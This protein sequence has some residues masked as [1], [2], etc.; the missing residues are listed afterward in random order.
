MALAVGGLPVL[1]LELQKHHLPYGDRVFIDV[2]NLIVLVA[3]GV[4]YV[5]ELVLASNRPVYVRSEYLSL[6]IVVAQALT[7]VPALRHVRGAARS[8]ASASSSACLPV[9]AR[10]AAIG[11]AASRD[12]RRLI[13]E[14]AASFALGMAAVTWLTSAAAFTVA[15]DVGVD[16]HVHSFLDRA[17]VVVVDD[18]HR[19]LRRHLSRDGGRSSHRR[20]HDDRRHLDVRHRHGEDCTVPRPLRNR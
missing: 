20:I 4:D 19:G 10:A 9:A 17:V 5:V 18:H 13:R 7:F 1:L 6:L 14:H 15:E 2:V 11:G 8:S 16:R 12:G 3:F